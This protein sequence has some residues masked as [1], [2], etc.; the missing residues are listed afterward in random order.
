M[1]FFKR[2]RNPNFRSKSRVPSR[3]RDEIRIE[4]RL[5]QGLGLD[6]D[7]NKI[8]LD[9]GVA[10]KIRFGTRT[11]LKTHPDLEHWFYEAFETLKML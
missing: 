2:D 11:G 1:Q 9:I 10:K 3:N 6:R 5:G 8:S 4:I 7:Q